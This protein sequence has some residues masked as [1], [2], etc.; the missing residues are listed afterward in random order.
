MNTFS[1][2]IS[3]LQTRLSHPLPAQEAHKRMASSLRNLNNFTFKH[4][5]PSRQSGVL[6]MLYPKNGE[7]YTA[8][9]KRT[10]DGYAH[11]GQ[12]SFPGGRMEPT[13]PNLQHTALRETEEE[14]GIDQ[15]LVNIVGS[16]SELYIP[17]SNSLV[18]PTV[19]SLHAPPTFMPNAAEVAQIIEVPINYLLDKKNIKHTIITLQNGLQIEAPYFDVFGHIVWGATAM[20]L[21]ELLQIVE[22][23]FLTVNYK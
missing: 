19:G 7:M 21:S 8:L 16:L 13:D 12:I 18:L 20:M 4:T 14:F 11:S 23:T 9:M 17:A 2:F 5:Q 10:E 1:L 3:Q 22:E 15:N 6:A